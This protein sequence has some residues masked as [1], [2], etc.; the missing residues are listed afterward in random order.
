MEKTLNFIFGSIISNV[1]SLKI[2]KAP[3]EQFNTESYNVSVPKDE[4]GKV[5]GKNGSIIKAIRLLASIPMRQSGK[6]LK[7]NLIEV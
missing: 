7:L 2:E 4:M 1:E 3:D 5:I 6:Y